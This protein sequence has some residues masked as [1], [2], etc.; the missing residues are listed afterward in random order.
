[1]NLNIKTAVFM[2]DLGKSEVS[3]TTETII[4]NPEV[5]LNN[6]KGLVEDKNYIPQ[7]GDKIFF[8]P[9]CNVPRFKVKQFCGT[10]GVS[11]V[12]YK[13]KANVKFVGELSFRQLVTTC[14]GYWYTKESFLNYLVKTVGN[15]SEYVGLITAIKESSS[16][17]VCSHNY[18]VKRQLDEA[19]LGKVFRPEPI[20][21]NEEP[22]LMFINENAHKSFVTL[23][24]DNQLYNQNEILRRINTGGVMGDEQYISIQRMLNSS[25]IENVKLAMEGMANCDYEKSCVPL[26]IL[27]KEYGDILYKSPTVNHVNFKSLLKFFEVQLP[28]V[29]LDGIIKA[30]LKRKLLNKVNLDKLMPMAIEQMKDNARTAYFTVDKIGIEDSI[31]QGLEE[32]ILDVN[33]DTE[34][35]EDPQE[36]IN[37]RLSYL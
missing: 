2:T 35:I 4:E 20:A 19:L 14:H 26:L 18:I 3:F 31:K 7:K 33:C 6:F 29:N 25:D 32:N 15:V 10:F 27:I 30:L 36:Q 21:G 34:I 8:I 28:T 24:E 23:I 16:E 13:E 17:F 9:G 12:K 5:N 1:M 11:L 22:E 37:P